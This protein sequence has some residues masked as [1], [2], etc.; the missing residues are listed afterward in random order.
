MHHNEKYN[1]INTKDKNSGSTNI[2]NVE[3]IASAASGGALIA[4]GLKRSDITGALLTAAGAVLAVRGATGHSQIYDALGVNTNP[5]VPGRGW[6][7]GPVN[8]S[9]SVTINKSAEELYGFWRNFEN[10]PQFMN[11]LESVKADGGKI[12]HWK[13]KAPLGTTVDWDAEITED[14]QNDKIAWKS[15]EGSDITNSGSVQFLP[16]TN[17]GTVVKV[18]FTYD[19]PAGKLGALAAKLFGEEPQQQ[20]AED[21]RRLKSLMETGLI[22]KVEGQTSG[23]EEL[24]KAKAASSR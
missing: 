14:V 9:K 20:V 2:G 11:H 17:R 19:A 22:M 16:T 12:S 18:E 15:I 5:E 7:S 24:P 23:R 4:Y 6:L 21:L 3:R 13:A 8:V 1:E 10:L